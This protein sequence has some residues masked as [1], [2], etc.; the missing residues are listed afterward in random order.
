MIRVVRSWR[1]R[2]V[3][4]DRIGVAVRGWIRGWIRGR[5]RREKRYEKRASVQ[6]AAFL[7]AVA[8][9]RL[10]ALLQAAR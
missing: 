1:A 4:P 7:N 9:K 10:P 6:E 5:I 2:S 8:S 3:A